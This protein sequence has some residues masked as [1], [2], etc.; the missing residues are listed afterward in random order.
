MDW[1]TPCGTGG[2]R[3]KVPDTISIR[4][5]MWGGWT[6]PSCGAKV[7]KWGRKLQSEEAAGPQ[8]PLSLRMSEQT[9]KPM[10]A[11][12]FDRLRPRSTVS[13]VFILALI[14]LNIWYD[15]YHPLGVIFDVIFVIILLTRDPNKS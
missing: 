14:A 12:I 8:A 6:C 7:D 5:E 13:W 2:V 10:R 1:K 11:T 15:Y 4:E 9:H 3:R